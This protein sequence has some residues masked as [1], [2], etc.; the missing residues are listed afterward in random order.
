VKPFERPSLIAE[1]EPE[2]ITL[3]RLAELFDPDVLVGADRAEV[4]LLAGSRVR[5]GALEEGYW[6][7]SRGEA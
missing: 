3:N 4:D 2:A 1:A 6:C 7:Y 5:D